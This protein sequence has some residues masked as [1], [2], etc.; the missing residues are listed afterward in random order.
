MSN[1]TSK[2]FTVYDIV[3][4]GVMAAI[5]L[6]LTYFIRIEIP[7]PAGPTNLKL[8]NAFIMI[9][10]ITLGGLRGGLAGGIGSVIFDIS[11]PAYVSSAPFTLG[12]FFLMGFVTGIVS[13]IGQKRGKPLLWNLIGAA[14]GGLTYFV[15]HIGKSI[16]ELVLAGSDLSAAVTACSAKMVT[17]VI[18]LVIGI[19]IAVILAPAIKKALSASGIYR[20]IGR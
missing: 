14:L 6:A 18:N 8:A 19:V 15:L 12:F 4:V 1:V 17:S 11:N 20:K 10:G 13:G 16:F 3:V 5:I 7:T 2:R 9:A